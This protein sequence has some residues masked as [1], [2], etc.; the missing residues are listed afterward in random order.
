MAR[1]RA[2]TTTATKNISTPLP[3]KG[4][5]QQSRWPASRIPLRHKKDTIHSIWDTDS[6][7][8]DQEQRLRR[9]FHDILAPNDPGDVV[10]RLRSHVDQQQSR[11]EALER[12]N[13]DFEYHKRALLA[14][15]QEEFNALKSKYRKGLLSIVDRW[16][17]QEA[18]EQEAWMNRIQQEADERVARVEDYWR[19]QFDSFRKQQE[20]T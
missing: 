1:P 15:Q 4:H 16:L 9:V 12:Q 5:M 6:A 11:I 3:H 2:T 8:E 20:S 10:D 19:K 14:R 13:D 17:S 7:D 18:A